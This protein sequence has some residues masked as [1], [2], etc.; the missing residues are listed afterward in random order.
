MTDMT[1]RERWLAILDGRQP[2]RIPTD[3]WCTA[4]VIPRLPAD[5]IRGMAACMTLQKGV[6]FIGMLSDLSHGYPTGRGG[7]RTRTGC[8]PRGF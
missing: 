1:P 6:L 4:E 8:Y 3:L 5:P 2:D 7:N